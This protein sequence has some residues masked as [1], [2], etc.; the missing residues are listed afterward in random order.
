MESEAAALALT[1]FDLRH[2]KAQ[3]PALPQTRQS[4]LLR[5][6]YL[7]SEVSFPSAVCP[8]AGVV[9]VDVEKVNIEGVVD[10]FEAEERPEPNVK[11]LLAGFCCYCWF[12]C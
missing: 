3:C 5:R 12:F 9:E 2:S 6:Y 10:V 4:L 8:A 7:S 1:L 11:L